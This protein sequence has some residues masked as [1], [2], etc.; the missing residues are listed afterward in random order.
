MGYVAAR[1]RACQRRNV[2]LSESQL[3]RKDYV[4]LQVDAEGGLVTT[5]APTGLNFLPQKRP[6]LDY[7]VSVLDES[8]GLVSPGETVKLRVDVTAQN[9]PAGSLLVALRNR[10]GSA[11]KLVGARRR[12][13]LLQPGESWSAELSFEAR[14]VTEALEFDLTVGA[15]KE[16]CGTV[17]VSCFP[18]LP[19]HHPPSHARASFGEAWG[20]ASPRRFSA[21]ADLRNNQQGD[22]LQMFGAL[23]VLVEGER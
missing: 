11:V 2:E 21:V 23:R 17:I 12:H 4:S 1:K 3:T 5:P 16:G 7:H 10:N 14:N 9:H 6:T 20:N 15:T 8:D 13:E 19:I 22:S 18:W